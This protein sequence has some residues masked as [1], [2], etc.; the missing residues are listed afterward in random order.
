MFILLR[1][2]SGFAEISIAI[3]PFENVDVNLIVSISESISKEYN[4]A[5]IEIL[6]RI[7]LPSSAFYKPRNRYRAEKILKYLNII[8]NGKFD[9]IVGL[10]DKD[11]STTLHGHEDWGVFGL[12]E[13]VGGYSCVVSIYRLKKNANDE[14]LKT[15]FKKIIIHELGHAFGLKHCDWSRCVMTEYKG[16][17]KTLDEEQ[18]NL[19]PICR[20]KID[21]RYK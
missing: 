11:I 16:T 6:N 5:K 15:R 17:M 14:L 8:K 9:K 3:Q 1:S 19:C 2:T 7:D 18:I 4:N 10:T 21:G 12:T 20:R 13:K